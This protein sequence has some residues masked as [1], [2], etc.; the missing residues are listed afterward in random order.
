MYGINKDKW[1]ISNDEGTEFGNSQYTNGNEKHVL[2]KEKHVSHT[3]HATQTRKPAFPTKWK[4]TARRCQ[5]FL[6]S[7]MKHI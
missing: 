4:A 5:A 2:L 3:P 6:S 1:V 7:W